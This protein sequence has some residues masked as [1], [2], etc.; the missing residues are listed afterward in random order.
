MNKPIGDMWAAALKSG[1][2]TQGKGYLCSESNGNKRFCCLG[3][4]CDLYN[5]HNPPM[6]MGS[7]EDGDGIEKAIL[8]DGCSGN[9]PEDVIKWSGMSSENGTRGFLK[10]SLIVLNDTSL[11]SFMD[12]ASVIEEEWAQL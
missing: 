7:I 5:K 4:L 3:V 12:I 8:F 6:A 2:Y 9:L 11:Y 10:P 1:E